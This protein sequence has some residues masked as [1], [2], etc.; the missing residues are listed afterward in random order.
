MPYCDNFDDF[1]LQCKLLFNDNPSKCRYVVKYIAASK[2]IV[3]KITDNTH[4]RKRSSAARGVGAPL[5]VF[6]MQ[7]E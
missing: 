4:V 6:A 5:R 2:Q 1:A 7:R 3:L